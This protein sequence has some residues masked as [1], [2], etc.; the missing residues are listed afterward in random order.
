MSKKI[1]E[2]YYDSFLC[3]LVLLLWVRVLIYTFLNLPFH[4]HTYYKS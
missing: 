4:L 2:K 1:Y 3:L